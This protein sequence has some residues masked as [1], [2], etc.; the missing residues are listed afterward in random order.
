MA[1]EGETNFTSYFFAKC[2]RTVALRTVTVG[3]PDPGPDPGPDG[4]PG[5]SET[6]SELC[7]TKSMQEKKNSQ[8]KKPEWWV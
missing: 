7:N 8:D 3:G 6:A 2:E 1:E 4:R 5:L